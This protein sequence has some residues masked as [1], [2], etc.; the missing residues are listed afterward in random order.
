MGGKSIDFPR[1]CE[2]RILAYVAG[3]ANES[4]RGVVNR[5]G[6]FQTYYSQTLEESSA[7]AISWIGSIQMFLLCLI[8]TLV[9]S[10]YDAGHCRLILVVGTVST[11]LG[12]FMTSLC[13]K[14][15]QL[16]LAQGLLTGFGFGCLSLPGVAI[17]SQYFT[18]KKAFATGIAS[19]GNSSIG[20]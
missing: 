13:D 3:P 1:V 6:V 14:Y 4:Y 18:T 16:F 19:L 8:G 7:S 15:W 5:Y 9:G 20:Q 2:S 12:V 11:V 10:I 17:V